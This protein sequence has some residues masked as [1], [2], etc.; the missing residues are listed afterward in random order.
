MTTGQ[1]R[2]PRRPPPAASEAVQALP[3]WK[4]FVVQFSRE[5][6]PRVRT[7]SG[8]V[9]HMSSGRRARFESAR[10]LVAVLAKLLSEVGQ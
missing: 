8:R 1:A 2:N 7:F 5:T 3:V 9:E 10:E 6:D 4:A